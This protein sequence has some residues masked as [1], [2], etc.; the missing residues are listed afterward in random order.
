[1]FKKEDERI[2]ENEEDSYRYILEVL[3]QHDYFGIV[4]GWGDDAIYVNIPS[5]FSNSCFISDIR[6][7]CV[8]TR[9]ELIEYL[10][11]YPHKEILACDLQDKKLCMRV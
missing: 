2:P 5:N 3:K 7:S 4:S 1:M 6:S 11:N 9:M 8:S 10:D